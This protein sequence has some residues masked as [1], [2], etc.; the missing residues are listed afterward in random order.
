MSV[1]DI[2][3]TDKKY[4]LLYADSPWKQSKGGKKSVRTNSNGKP[5]EYPTESL[6][7]IESQ[8]PQANGLIDSG[9]CWGNEV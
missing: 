7:D 2:Y 9:D 4:S 3:N 6:E 1:I 8:L 5:I